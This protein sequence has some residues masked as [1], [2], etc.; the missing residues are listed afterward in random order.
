[1]LHSDM[2][3]QYAHVSYAWSYANAAARTGAGGF[4]AGDVGKLARQTDDN[5]LWLLSATTPTWVQVSTVTPTFSS[6][7]VTGNTTLGDAAGDSVT[8]NGATWTWAGSATRMIGDF[9]NATISNRT[10]F[11]TSTTDAG[12]FIHTFANGTATSS[13]FLSN[14]ASDPTNSSEAGM[15]INATEFRLQAGIRGTGTYI[16]IHMVTNNTVRLT[17]DTSGN[18]VVGLGEVADAAT[19]GF[20]Y[21]TGTT[22]G[23]PSGTP[24][25]YSGRHPMVVDDTN[26]RLYVNIGGTWK[27]AALT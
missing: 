2:G 8:V 16:P 22:A 20:L 26:N 23:A 9:S 19:D 10:A 5:S 18:T 25:S 21:I 27:Y 7:N 14:N 15:F 3:L 24:T 4:V 17:I 11:V 12:T 1:M 6:L 13:G